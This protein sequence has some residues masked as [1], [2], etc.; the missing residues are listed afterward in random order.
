RV[1]QTKNNGLTW[2]EVLHLD[3]VTHFHSC[4]YDPYNPNHIYVNTGDRDY[5]IEGPE[6]MRNQ[7]HVSYDDGATWEHIAGGA[8]DE[9]Q[10][11]LIDGRFTSDLFLRT[12][13]MVMGVDSGEKGRNSIFY[14]HDN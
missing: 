14:M 5:S 6:G 1:M 3:N 2:N 12:T 10:T 13:A 9:G 11:P 7:W 8:L 4:R